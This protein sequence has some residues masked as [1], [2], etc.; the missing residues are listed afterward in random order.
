[1]KNEG[2]KWGDDLQKWADV[3][4]ELHVPLDRR[5]YELTCKRISIDKLQFVLEKYLKRFSEGGAKKLWGS[6]SGE[7]ESFV[8]AIMSDQ[9]TEDGVSALS[10]SFRELNYIN[11]V[12]RIEMGYFKNEQGV[13][14]AELND[15]FKD[16]NEGFTT[17]SG[18]MSASYG[19]STVL[20]DE[21]EM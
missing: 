17:V 10:L 19:E 21:G 5:H 4:N 11:T 18:L 1:M 12:F 6:D 2:G 13:V 20:S 3:A 16:I 7:F 9:R 15:A 14:P 8:T